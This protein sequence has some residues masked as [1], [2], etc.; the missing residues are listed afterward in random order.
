MLK[1]ML[2]QRFAR[3]AAASLGLAGLLLASACTPTL[4][5]RGNLPD[6]EDVLA[7]QPGE[8]TREQVAQILGSPSVVGT[9]DDNTWYYMSRRTETLAFFDPEVVDG[10]VLVVKFDDA[11]VVSDMKLYGFEDGRLIDPVDRETPNLGQELTVLQQLFGNLG[12]FNKSSEE[13]SGP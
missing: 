9:F 4:D 6:P 7:V 13:P 5:V 3:R 12:R 10:Q 1:S 2:R 11:G 8:S